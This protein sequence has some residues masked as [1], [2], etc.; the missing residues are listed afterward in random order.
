MLQISFEVADALLGY[1]DGVFEFVY[2]GMGFSLPYFE[3][4]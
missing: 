1:F 2:D 3:Q 4:S